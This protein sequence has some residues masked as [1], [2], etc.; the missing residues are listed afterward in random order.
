LVNGEGLNDR[1]LQREPPLTVPQPEEERGGQHKN[2]DY[3]DNLNP[4]QTRLSISFTHVR[5]NENKI[6]HRRVI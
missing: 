2:G 1:I 5:S 3:H 4:C 6:S